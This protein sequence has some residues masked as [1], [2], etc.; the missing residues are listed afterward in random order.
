MPQGFK[1]QIDR[2]GP[3][4]AAARQRDPHLPESSQRRA[5]NEDRSAHLADQIVGRRPA[6]FAVG[7]QAQDSGPMFAVTGPAVHIDGDAEL[8][9]QI[10][11]G[12]NIGQ[13]RR[14]G[15]CQGLIGQQTRRHQR[16]RRILGP[17]D[18]NGAVEGSS[19]SNEDLIHA[20]P[21]VPVPCPPAGV[22]APSGG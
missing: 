22:A 20:S 1:V 5:Q 4:G 3:N 10:R 6:D 14:I 8:G 19:A 11:H 7:G 21:F 18:G 16:Q 17:G 13:V 12:R 2:P 15:Q 9:Q